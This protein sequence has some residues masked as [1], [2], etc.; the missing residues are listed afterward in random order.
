MTLWN[1]V[2]LCSTLLPTAHSQIQQQKLHYHNQDPMVKLKRTE[3]TWKY[4]ATLTFPNIRFFQMFPL[5]S[6]SHQNHH[7]PPITF[8]TVH[9]IQIEVFWVVTLC[10][11]G[12]IRVHPKASRL[13]W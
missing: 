5:I 6:F 2:E 1:E 9:H 12:S 7:R 8:V 11:V 3:A 13:S 4:S 10:S